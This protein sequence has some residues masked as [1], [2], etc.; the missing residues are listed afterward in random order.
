[1]RTTS[2]AMLG[3]WVLMQA[4]S[5]GAEIAQWEMFETSYESAK[6]Y[7]NAF[8]DV[9]VDV[10]FKQGE[11]QW[12][13]PAFWAGDKMW[14]VRFA[15]PG[16]GDYKYRVECTDKENTGL[17]GNEQTLS[18]GVYKGDNPLLKHGFVEVSPGKTCFEYADGT[19]FFWLG[20]T[21]WMGLV[22]RL[23]W[24]EDLH[25]LTVDRRDKGFTVVQIV[26]GLYP[27][28]AAF[29]ERGLGEAGQPGEKP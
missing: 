22:K 25:R 11:K 7:P 3:L 27:D 13:V 8:K 6:E 16:Q 26:A 23:Q 5:C 1:M 4:G 12:K 17:N 19:P 28:M 29:D 20:D 2:F 14:T 10:V 21:W 9:E 18:V 24:P 15:P